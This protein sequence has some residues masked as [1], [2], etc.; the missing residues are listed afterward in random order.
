M[1][2]Q[3]TA[4]GRLTIRKAVRARLVACLL[5]ALALAVCSVPLA[6]RGDGT[7]AGEVTVLLAYALRTATFI[8]GAA[9]LW[10]ACAAVSRD[11]EG[12][13]ILLVAV[14]PVRPCVLWFGQW[15]G[16][17]TLA[18]ALLALS[19]VAV[20]ALLALRLTTGGWSGEER[21]QVR[22]DLLV[23]R[24][25]HLPETAGLDREAHSLLAAWKARGHAPA[26]VAD[27]ALL[28]M[29]RRRLQSARAAAAPGT[30]RQWTFPAAATRAGAL[31]LS[32]RVLSA[33]GDRGPIAGAW[34]VGPPADP[35]RCTLPVATAVTARQRFDIPA[36]ACVAGEPLVVTFRNAA[37]PASVTALFAGPDAVTLLTAAGG[38]AGNLVRALLVTFATLAALAALGLLAGTLFSFPVAAFTAC[39]VVLAVRLAVTFPDAGGPPQQR[40]GGAHGTRVAGRCERGG[41]ALLLGVRRAATPFNRIDPLGRLSEGIAV[42]N[43]EVAAALLALAVAWPAVAGLLS[44][45]VLKRR[46]LASA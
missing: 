14:K 23:A 34:H 4:I 5:A 35:D 31:S 41:A 24:R 43:R 46:E 29:I 3:L 10:A 12:R 30:A 16:I 15:L 37:R 25:R 18:A 28:D 40:H 45:C 26:A 27:A 6:V 1:I 33:P 39:A 32:V 17:V 2:G 9:T 8:L 11:I 36:S 38:F 20:S 44:G 7:A 21:R 13:Q 19:A 42:R 22:E